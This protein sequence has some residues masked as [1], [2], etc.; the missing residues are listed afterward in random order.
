MWGVRGAEL[1]RGFFAVH[2]T[3]FF[4]AGGSC[5]RG[6]DYFADTIL[7][8][9]KDSSDLPHRSLLNKLLWISH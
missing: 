9:K 1:E 2:E 7:G 3:R 4:V 8:C 5:M 6:S